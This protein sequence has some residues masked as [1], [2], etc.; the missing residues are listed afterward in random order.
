MQRCLLVHF[1]FLFLPLV[2]TAQVSVLTQHNNTGRTGWN[3]KE[4]LL[5]HTNVLP[6]KFGLTGTLAVDDEVY[7]QPLIVPAITIGAYKGNVLFTATVNNTVY[8]FNADDVSQPAPLWQVNLNPLWQ[9]APDIF[10]L[11]DPVN[12]KPCGGNY[13]DFSGR[14]GLVGTPVIDTVS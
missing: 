2:T 6:G 10:D 13:R 1:L 12:G 3:D 5:N 4:V 9:R 7:A 8:A 14:L 11:K